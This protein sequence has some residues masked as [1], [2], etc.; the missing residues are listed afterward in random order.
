MGDHAHVYQSFVNF[1]NVATQKVGFLGRRPAKPECQTLF[2]C[3]QKLAVHIFRNDCSNWIKIL[4]TKE[5]RYALMPFTF[6]T[7][8]F[9][10]YS[11][12]KNGVCRSWCSF[13]HWITLAV[14]FTL[15]KM[16][17]YWP[18]CCTISI[19]C[20]FACRSMV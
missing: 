9:I 11:A 16:H 13:I 12:C 14:A 3:S 15:V 17:P 5:N 4:Q 10:A 19:T 6:L 20:D 8:P 7:M 2:G 18:L 1:L